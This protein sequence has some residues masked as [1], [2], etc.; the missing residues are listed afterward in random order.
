MQFD[1]NKYYRKSKSK[2]PVLAPAN[3]RLFI[4]LRKPTKGKI[5]YRPGC[6]LKGAG[7][8]MFINLTK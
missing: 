8:N 7:T 6:G 2:L 5:I 4:K 1:A 3:T